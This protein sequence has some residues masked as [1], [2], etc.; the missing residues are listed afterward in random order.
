MISR[1]TFLAAAA[2]APR[3][4]SAE[5]APSLIFLDAGDP[6]RLRDFARRNRAVLLDR[7]ASAALK[8]GPWSVTFHRPAGL[9]VPANDY[10]SDA[11]YFWPDPAHPGGPYIRKDGEHYPDRFQAN[12]TDLRAMSAAVLSLGMG[13]YLL[14]RSGCAP[15][16]VRVLSTWFLDPKTRMNP[17]LEHGQLIRGVNTGRGA[18]Q[19]DCRPLMDVAQ[20]VVLLELAGGFD[21][22][23]AQGVRRWYADYLHWMLTSTHGR[24]EQKAGNNHATWWTAQAASHAAFTSDA[25]TLEMAW[26]HFRDYLVP[27][28]IRPDGSCPREEERT[29]SLHYSAM[30]LDAFGVLCRLAQVAGVDLWRFRAKNGAGVV[31]AFDYVLPYLLHPATWKKRQIDAVVPGEHYFPGLAGIGLPSRPMLEAY[32]SLPRQETPWVSFIDILIGGL[33]A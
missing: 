3:L 19:I 20:G 33:A 24:S 28:E 1:R 18:G 26:N 6:P 27:Q 7:Y 29:R 4:A 31:T 14:G 16:A 30:N 12:V 5:S 25:A 9:D 15:H 10:V 32:R 22:E 23:V 2:V 13:A 21:R 17:H 11:P 8:S